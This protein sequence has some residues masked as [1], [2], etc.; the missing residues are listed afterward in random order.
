M[1]SRGLDSGFA[2]SVLFGELVKTNLVVQIAVGV[3]D[4]NLRVSRV[5]IDSDGTLERLSGL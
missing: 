3:D 4:G 2:S 1:I 5:D